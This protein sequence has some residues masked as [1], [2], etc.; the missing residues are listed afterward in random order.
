MHAACDSGTPN[1]AYNALLAWASFRWNKPFT[2]IENLPF[3]IQLESELNALQA[4]CFHHDDVRWNGLALLH[5]LR[6][7]RPEKKTKDSE[8]DFE[9]FIH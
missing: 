7:V 9:G 3:A 2:C 8:K 1:A 6:H 5:A 4:A